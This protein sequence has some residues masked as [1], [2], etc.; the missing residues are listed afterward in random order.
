MRLAVPS[1]CSNEKRPIGSWRPEKHFLE[2]MVSGRGR[3]ELL[4]THKLPAPIGAIGLLVLGS[5]NLSE[6]NR[7]RTILPSQDCTGQRGLPE[8]M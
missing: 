6:E 8:P 7:G 2:A 1:W 4:S 5:P 3:W